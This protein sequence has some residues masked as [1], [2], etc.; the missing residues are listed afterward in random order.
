MAT[1]PTNKPIPSEDPRDLKFN[2]GKIDEVVTSDAHY[3]TDRFGVRRWTIAGFQYTAEEAIRN[4]GYI[5]MDSFE[6]GATLTLPN[7]VLRYEANGEYYR[8]DGEFPKTV[9]SGSTPEASGGIGLGA[10]VSVGDAALRSE[11]FNQ[12]LDWVTPDQFRSPDAADDTAAFTAA[13]AASKR[14]KLMARTYYVNADTII[15]RSDDVYIIGEGSAHTKIVANSA[16]SKLIGLDGAEGLNYTVRQ[17]ISIQG[18]TLDGNGM[19]TN[20][21]TTQASQSPR[22][23]VDVVVTGAISHGFVHTRGWSTFAC[24]LVCTY[25]G[26]AGLYL[27]GDNNNTHWDGMWSHNTGV[28][29]YV[30]NAAAVSFTGSFENNGEQGCLV[31]ANATIASGYVNTESS[32]VTFTDGCYFESNGQ[33][34]AGTYPELQFGGNGGGTVRDCSVSAAHIGVPLSGIGVQFNGAAK[35]ITVDCSGL[36]PVNTPTAFIRY[37]AA[38]TNL[39]TVINADHKFINLNVAANRIL[40]LGFTDTDGMLAAYVLGGGSQAASGQDNILKAIRLTD[41][42]N[43]GTY[44]ERIYRGTELIS[45]RGVKPN[46]QV[47]NNAASSAGF[48]SF[49]VA[50]TEVFRITS[51]NT[52]P[53]TDNSTSLGTPSSRWSTVY[54]GTG[55]INTSDERLKVAVYSDKY[56]L[57]NEALAAAEIK[58]SIYRFKFTDSITNK[59]E[60]YSRI[61]FGVGAQTVHDILIKYGLNPSDY[62]FW[63][64][65]EWN[66]EFDDNGDIIIH[67]GNRYGIRYDELCMFIMAYV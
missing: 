6:D 17:R 67:A 42:N 18:V 35:R 26:G 43:T 12:Y 3:Y 33:N 52:R 23:A 49:A 47:W 13:L 57:N 46:V 38:Y 14:I 8:W 31:D 10:W 27:V 20:T 64:Y 4:Y 29:V 28:G 30:Q 58:K 7:Q 53:V 45:E 50:G 19:V 41:A 11:I 62:A 37:S 25:N 55:T 32:V 2:A 51:T 16:G 61:H 63:C 60:Q 34:T 66:D 36:Y 59:G 21:I 1:T 40:S 39:S 5:T 56:T 54:A 22:L 44:L 65:D 24:G 48:H 15:T 9:P